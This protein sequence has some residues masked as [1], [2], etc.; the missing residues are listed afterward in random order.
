M[1][2]LY[3]SQQEM[4]D[5]IKDKTN[6]AIYAGVGSGKTFI[7]S[8]KLLSFQTPFNLV[9]CQKSQVD[10]WVNHFQTH[11]PDITVTDL[12]K[13]KKMNLTHIRPGVMN[14][15]SAGRYYWLSRISV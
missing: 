5:E 14:W 8:E 13:V 12:T 15:L 3:P 2:Q 1:V 7:G 10:Y 9:I 11:Y 6:C 4:L